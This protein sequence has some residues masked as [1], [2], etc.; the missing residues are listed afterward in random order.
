MDRE[1]F[2]VLFYCFFILYGASF[3]RTIFDRYFLLIAA[4]VI[5]VGVVTLGVQ[6]SFIVL[7]GLVPVFASFRFLRKRLKDGKTEATDLKSTGEA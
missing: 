6:L 2:E 3:R 1:T 4:V 7:L 5:F